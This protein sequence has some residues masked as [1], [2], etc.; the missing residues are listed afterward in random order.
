MNKQ[1]LRAMKEEIVRW[2]ILLLESGE[3]DLESVVRDGFAGVE[4]LSDEELLKEFKRGLAFDDE[5]EAIEF[6]RDMG[7]SK[8]NAATLYEVYKN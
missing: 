6:F 1:I 7:L 5:H 4:S 8:K 2:N 3:I